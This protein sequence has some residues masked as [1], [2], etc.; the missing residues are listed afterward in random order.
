MVQ[1]IATYTSLKKYLKNRL[2]TLRAKNPLRKNENLEVSPPS[3]V[4][5]DTKKLKNKHNF[6]NAKLF[7][8]LED[9]TSIRS[10]FTK[11]P[12]IC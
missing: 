6:V 4:L 10:A 3:K 8:L 11:Q 5:V 2:T 1:F 9:S 7:L 12:R